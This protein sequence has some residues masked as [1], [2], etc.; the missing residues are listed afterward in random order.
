M[1]LRTGDPLSLQLLLPKAMSPL[2]FELWVLRNLCGFS[3]SW[4]V[5][6][7]ILCPSVLSHHCRVLL[8]LVLVRANTVFWIG[9]PS[10]P[11]L[12]FYFV[13]WAS[14]SPMYAFRVHL[15]GLTIL[16]DSRPRSMDPPEAPIVKPNPA[17][18]S[19]PGVG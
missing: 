5:P 17:P 4:N 19:F 10:F 3:G 7:C 9:A 11:I 18:P 6:S 12:D 13:G 2:A 16:R 8:L 15:A 1:Q 14:V